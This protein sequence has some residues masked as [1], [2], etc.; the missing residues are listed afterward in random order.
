MKSQGLP[1][2]TIVLVVIAVVV[3][4]AVMLFFF[5][6]MKSGEKPTKQQGEFANCQAICTQINSES[7]TTAAKAA[8]IAD[9]LNFCSKKCDEYLTCKIDTANCV[10]GCNPTS[11]ITPH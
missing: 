7:P 10:I 1:M 2:Q 9:G 11:C 3:M 4:V 6:S 5:T 8:S